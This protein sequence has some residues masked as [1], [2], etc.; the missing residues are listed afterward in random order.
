MSVE[1]QAR[2][3]EST[4]PMTA[5]NMRV[6][7]WITEQDYQGLHALIHWLRGFEAGGN[8]GRVPGHHELVSHFR[9]L[10]TA[11]REAQKIQ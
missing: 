7:V 8:H 6:P 1:P 5:P 10:T 9:L 3:P 2:I 11:I 4:Q